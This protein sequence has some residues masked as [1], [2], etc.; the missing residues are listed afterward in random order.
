MTMNESSE[1]KVDEGIGPLCSVILSFLFHGFDI[2]QTEKGAQAPLLPFLCCRLGDQ[3]NVI[4]L[5]GNSDLIEFT[6]EGENSPQSDKN[7]TLEFIV[8]DQAEV[9]RF[10]GEKYKE[11][12]SASVSL[13]NII[14]SIG[15]HSFDKK[16]G[17]INI[18]C[19]GDG[20]SV[21]LYMSAELIFNTAEEVVDNDRVDMHIPY[22]L[23]DSGIDLGSE[24]ILSLSDSSVIECDAQNDQIRDWWS[25]DDE[26]DTHSGDDFSFPSEENIWHGLLASWEKEKVVAHEKAECETLEEMEAARLK[27]LRSNPEVA[28]L[29]CEQSSFLMEHYAHEERCAA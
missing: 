18:S 24:N 17:N 20:N 2:N 22:D 27:F 28:M 13:N 5:N 10:S 21:E 1:L 6:I 19:E 11:V 14:K 12:A 7:D 16:E 25:E 15:S 26:V 3:E 8:K 4:A 23:N 9:P 29:A